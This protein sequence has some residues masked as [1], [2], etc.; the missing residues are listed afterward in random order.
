M[1]TIP[2]TLAVA[3]QHHRGG[4]IQ[5][6]EQ[7]Y[8][9]VLQ[10]EPDHA[11]AL[12]LLGVIAFQVGRYEFAVEH[13][14][15]AIRLKGDSADYYDHL[16]G[17]HHALRKV[18]EAIACFRRALELR[19]DY[20]EAHN[21]LGNALADEGKHNEAAACYRRALELKPDYAQAA[22]NLGNVLKDLGKLDDAAAS[23]RRALARQP[24]Y[25]EAHSNLGT[26]L[27]DQGKPEEA[28]ACYRRALEL[29]PDFAEAQNNLGVVLGD[30][31]KRDEAVA[32][33]QRTLE[34]KPDY[35]DAH[36]NLG[37]LLKDE[38]EL[39]EAAACFRLTLELRPDHVDAHNNLGNVLKDLGKLD[40]AVAC[41]RR[42]LELKPSFAEAHS[43][44]GRVFHDQGKLDDAVACYRRAL[45]AKP[46]YAE[47]HNN[48]GVALGDLERLDEAIAC[49]RR[50]L[51]LKPDH[52]VAVGALVHALQHQCCWEDL[53]SLSERAIDIV[54]QG[55]C[56][57]T[58]S[59]VL[60]F[61]FVTLA[62][63]TTAEQQLK[64]ARQW[65]DQQMK[66]I[67]GLEPGRPRHR[68]PALVPHAAGTEPFVV[69]PLGG[70]SPGFRLKAGL[71]T[72]K[73]KIVVGYVSADFHN[74]ATAWL[75]AELIE[76]HDRRR[77]AVFGYS[78]GLDNCS[79]MR[80]RLADAFDRFVKLK[81]ASCAEAAERVAADGVDILVDLK[82]YTKDAR[83]DVF[84]LR[85]APIQVN[86]LGYPGT[87]GADFMDYILVDDYIVPPDQQP[88]FSEKLV[89]LPGCYQVNDSQREISPRVP[90][91]EECGLPAEGLVFCAF[92][93]GY[94][95]TPRM[96][97]VWMRLLAAVPGSVLWLMEG[98]RFV[99]AN[100][101]REAEARGVAAERLV[102]APH[103]PLAEH[104][105]RHR[106]ADLFL[107]TFPVNAHTTASDCLWAGCPLLTLSGKT[108]VSR[109][110]G[111]LL[112][113][114]GLPELITTSLE[115]YEAAAL[116]LAREPGR[117]QDLRARLWK[118]RLTCGL[119]DGGRFAGNLERAYE[120]MWEIHASGEKPRSFRV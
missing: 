83:T 106:L 20:A 80:R 25:A 110:A 37:K 32:C 57:Q 93:N 47:V 75:I 26:V 51:E 9:Q 67:S 2:E 114:I 55:A 64:C 23:Y 24:N 28:I 21:N 11:D 27:K 98:N 8:R 56:G 102:M 119:F 29:R 7:L 61:T 104:L 91:R 81:D 66:S 107:D 30:L 34:L 13:I 58:A 113:T 82:G 74:H 36:N 16:G 52:T 22:Y 99:P 31:E 53:V 63:A 50:A 79:P 71:R 92:N 68:C 49:Y 6:A 35:A 40:E 117:L 118:N 90:S 5:A 4:R 97:N 86:Y 115:D 42:A 43:N 89:Y 70:F 14:A 18:P 72:S 38:G 33:F 94:K 103:L 101:R 76:K 48:L 59:P 100:L 116:R 15:R 69:P 96:F 78:N 62:A 12:H 77:F 10:V 85:P 19:P 60:P 45:E 109:V 87:M 65:V 39:D 120:T 46:D 95:I 112:R 84:A 105:A 88:F 54:E 3:V 41:Y 108:F 44:L 73:S 1:P 17:A 111:S